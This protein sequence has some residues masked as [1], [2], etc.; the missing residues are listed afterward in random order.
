MPPSKKSRNI[1]KK[2]KTEKRGKP[3]GTPKRVWMYQKGNIAY[4][5]RVPFLRIKPATEPVHGGGNDA[6]VMNKMFEGLKGAKEATT[7]LK[8]FLDGYKKEERADLVKSFM[9]SVKDKSILDELV[10]PAKKLAD[11]S[12][13]LTP[14][15]KTLLSW[16]ESR[17]KAKEIMDSIRDRIKDY[18]PEEQ[19]RIEDTLNHKESGSGV[20]SSMTT[21]A[22]SALSKGSSALGSFLTPA[23]IL[24][25]D[26]RLPKK[27]N[28][29]NVQLLWLPRSSHNYRKGLSS[30][31]PKE[32]VKYG[33]FMVYVEPE[34]YADTMTYLTDRFTSVEDFFANVL[35]GCTDGMC[36]KGDVK[37]KAFKHQVLQINNLQPE[38]DAQE[39]SKALSGPLSV[40]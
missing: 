24:D 23:S 37:R 14:A 2:R 38:M 19:K 20:L 5:V 17:E 11:G 4:C 32:D 15:G 3:K 39:Q 27:R 33:E 31:P 6:V 13:R 22:F 30:A 36:S 8:T 16:M 7:E 10:D 40:E 29:T 12:G 26:G 21:G 18:S 1:R 9:S 35:N 28:E 34:K 25:A